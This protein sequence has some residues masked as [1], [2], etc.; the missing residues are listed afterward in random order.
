MSWI[1]FSVISII[2]LF[3]CKQEVFKKMLLE[4]VNIYFLE[5]Y[6]MVKDEI[7]KLI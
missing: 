7:K 4:E 2:F 5:Q 1:S 3:I 6:L